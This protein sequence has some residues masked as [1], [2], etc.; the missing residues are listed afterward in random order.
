MYINNYMEK[1]IIKNSQELTSIRRKN[2]NKKIGL[3]HGSFDILHFGHLNHMLAS[4]KQVDVLIVSITADKF[5]KKGPL[6]P[7]NDEFKRSRML[8]ALE[9]VDYVY[10][11]QNV[12]AE[13]I[14]NYLRPDIYF[15]GADY[16]K[17]D[18][19]NNLK[20]EIKILKKN[21]GK[22]FY[23]KTELM[24]STKIL[25]NQ[26]A[27]WNNKQKK[28]IELIKSKNNF[29][30]ILKIFN[31]INKT[32]INV[33]GE[34]ILDEYIFCDLAGIA[35][36]SPTM[37]FVNKKQETYDGGVLAV[38]KVL[39]I[40]SKRVNL[41]TYG[42]H[43]LI[44]KNLSKYKNIKIINLNKNAII[45]K[46]TRIINEN[47]SEKIIQITNF[48]NNDFSEKDINK[49]I[50]I[51]K[52]F[53]FKELIFC[54][55]GINLFE[56]KF[57]KYVNS[58]K[59]IKKFINVQTNS[60][61]YGNNLYY[62]FKKFFFIS[63]DEN[64]WRLSQ[65]LKT[66]NIDVINKLSNKFKNRLFAVTCGKNG[67]Y[68]INNNKNYYS[69]VFEDRIIDTTGCG[70]AYFAISSLLIKINA[71][72]HIIPFLSNIYA[73]L[74]AQTLANKDIVSKEEYFKYIKSLINK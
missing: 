18:I 70:D 62:K 55:Y 16:L 47:R 65:N 34:P 31:K 57:L 68:L 29:S 17:E 40:F 37:S 71:P 64:E 54:D 1:K 22:I 11:D 36:K 66:L 46:K 26:F 20:K 52:K 67:S 9:F 19:S 12:T 44:K 72:F 39:S 3:C 6:Q 60:L 15:K 14:I 45:Q 7:Y 8:S 63:L 2:K 21:N 30:S 5:I 25:N 41:F 43:N 73:G 4:R 53:R 35:S 23:T 10:I 49:K 58:L 28:I 32:T 69:P 61:N 13:K 42:N 59:N 48:K 27:L 51:L 56:K 33:I 24:S 74:H 38:A 50:Q